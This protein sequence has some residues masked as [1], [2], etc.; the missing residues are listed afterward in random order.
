MGKG[1]VLTFKSNAFDL[2][3]SLGR[4]QEL[5]KSCQKLSEGIGSISALECNGVVLFATINAQHLYKIA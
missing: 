4:S 5:S 2:I 3:P 1:I